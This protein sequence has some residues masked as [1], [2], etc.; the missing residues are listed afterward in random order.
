M[1]IIS[2]ECVS[3]ML[4]GSF[5]APSLL[6]FISLGTDLYFLILFGVKCYLWQEYDT[7]QK[8]FD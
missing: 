8:P 3:M 5:I 6:S 2:I 7:S 4:S 1:L